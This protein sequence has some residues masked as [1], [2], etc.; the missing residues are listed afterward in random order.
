MLKSTKTLLM[1]VATASALVAAPIVYATSGH[2]DG[3]RGK[4]HDRGGTRWAL[5]DESGSIIRQ[6]GGFKTV[7]CFKTNANCYIDIGRD[8]RN[9]G[10]GA[11]I[12]A[13]N[14]VPGQAVSLA[15]EIGVG[16]CG[17]DQINCAPPGTENRNVIVVAPRNSDGSTTTPTTRKRFY[18]QVLN[19]H[20]Y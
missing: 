1:L 3:S 20:G 6:T 7:D 14:N 8:A 2:D 16:A 9:K 18:V 13:Q 11:T 4:H 17:I 15:G 12:A 19:R 10:L 5:V